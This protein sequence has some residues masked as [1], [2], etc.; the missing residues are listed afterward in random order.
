MSFKT[1]V[2]DKKLYYKK[3]HATPHFRQLAEKPAHIPSIARW[4]LPL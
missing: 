1:Q 4:Q 3:A 2:S